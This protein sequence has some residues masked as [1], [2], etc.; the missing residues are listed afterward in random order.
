MEIS[1]KVV[2]IGKYSPAG[3]VALAEATIEQRRAAMDKVYEAL[4][5]KVTDYFWCDGEHDFVI[6]AEVPD[7]AAV[8]GMNNNAIASGSV[9]SLIVCAEVDASRLTEA[10]RTARDAFSSITEA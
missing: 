9:E 1:M 2:T 4:G 7:K 5:G 6:V 10:Q 3:R 8:T